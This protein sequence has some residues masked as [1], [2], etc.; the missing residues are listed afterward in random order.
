MNSNI[1]RAICIVAAAAAFTSMFGC[2]VN[3]TSNKDGN[4]LNY[5]ALPTENGTAEYSFKFKDMDGKEVTQKIDI[6]MEEVDN[7]E[8]VSSGDIASD[9]FLKGIA[10][11]EYQM[12]DKTAQ[13]VASDPETY[14][15]FQFIE[16]VQ[17]K[18]DKTM[19]YKDVAVKDNGKN[20]IW[21][22]TALDAEYT[23]APGSVAPIYVFG[24]ADM[25]KYTEDELEAAFAEINVKLLYTLVNSAQDDVDWEGTRMSEMDIH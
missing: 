18:S 17:N 1:K 7:I 13:K 9:K 15:E 20:G 11:N 25:S 19:A 3:K 16:Y 22:K 8:I 2:T 14:K 21:I 5:S 23:I 24:I 10:K 12:D 4:V 6:D